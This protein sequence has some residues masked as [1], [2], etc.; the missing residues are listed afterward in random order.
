MKNNPLKA[1]PLLRLAI[2]L[3]VGIVLG[4]HVPLLTVLP[5]CFVGMVV[6]ALLLWRYATLQ[7]LVIAACF[8]LLGWLLLQRQRASLE[9]RWPDGQVQNEAVVLSEPMEKPKTTAVDVM[10]VRDGRKIKCYLYKDKRSRSLHIGDGLWIQSRIRRVGDWRIG[11]FNYRHYLEERG[12]VGTT[13]VASWNWRKV[14]VSLRDLSYLQRTQLGFLKSRSRILQHLATQ[15]LT[16]EH[17]AVVSAMVL[18]DK[19]SLT[20]EVKNLYSVTGASHVLALSGLHL[21]IIYTLLSLLVVR[22]R[23]QTVSQF[24]IVLSIWAFVFLTGMSGSLIRSAV[25]LSLYALLSLGH[26]DKMSVN[27]LAFTAIV[28]LMVNPLSLYDVGF[29]LSFMAVFAIL[30]WLPLF[31]EVFSWKYLQSHRLA[32]WVWALVSV[33]C[34]AQIGVAPLI[35]Y[36]FGHFSTFF[37][38][39]NFIVVPAATLILYLSLIVLLVP[40]FTYILLYVVGILH[41]VLRYIASVPGSSMGPLHPTLLQV[42]MV[43]VIVASLYLLIVRL[44][45]RS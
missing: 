2:C 21:G 34:A 41:S 25:M 27:T 28:M 43:Y 26:R 1:C 22:R 20:N 33:S 36:Y 11:R 37:L 44:C 5:F 29:Q 13:F 19:S 16:D 32:K 38:P 39:T 10:L 42:M 14:K 18:G 15:G 31:D 9:V 45:N 7:S 35:A 23:W 6:L 40:S 30:L 3:M 24:L 12:F 4:H 8:V 17:Y